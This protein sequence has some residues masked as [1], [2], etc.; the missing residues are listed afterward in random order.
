MKPSH[1]SLSI[2][3]AL[4]GATACT[5]PAPESRLLVLD[6]LVIELAELEPFLAFMDT[7]APDIGRKTKMMRVL[8]QYLIPLHLA[9]RHFG[10]QRAEKLQQA[11]ALCAV[12]TNVKELEQRAELLPDKVL[13]DEARTTMSLP[14]AMFLFDPLQQGGVSKPIEVPQGWHVVGSFEL[15]EKPLALDDVVKSLRVAFDTHTAGQWYQWYEEQK[16]TLA[17]K[18]TFVHPDWTT[19]I[20]EWIHPP[21]QP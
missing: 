18:A 16:K 8:E 11:E 15:R 20:P 1:R 3:A 14:E 13:R 4:L 5:K 19:A 17:D 2:V 9:R 21:K 7:W 6:G 12:A 10:P